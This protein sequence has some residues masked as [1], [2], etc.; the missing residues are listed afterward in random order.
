MSWAGAAMQIGGGFLRA[1]GAKSMAEDEAAILEY[2]AALADEEAKTTRETTAETQKLQRDRM[3][4]SLASNRA[5]TASS[6]LMMKGTPAAHQLDVID[7]YA[8]DIARTGQEGEVQAL[9]FE[10]Q[11]DI[12]RMKAEAARK[13]GKIEYMSHILGGGGGAIGSMS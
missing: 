11:G 12:Y 2:N 5:V 8:Y 10:S 7:D 4:K 6:G 13:R 9:R 3:R 1:E